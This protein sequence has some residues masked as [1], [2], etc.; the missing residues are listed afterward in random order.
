MEN[1]ED[2]SKLIDF[3]NVELHKKHKIWKIAFVD[4]SF[5]WLWKVE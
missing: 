2:F 1:T 4:I 3:F 5:K